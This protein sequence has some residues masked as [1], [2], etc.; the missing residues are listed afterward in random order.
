MLRILIVFAIV[1]ETC[2][3]RAGAQTAPETLPRPLKAGDAVKYALAHNPQ[4]LAL[5]A[6][7]AQ[8]E[9]LYA[10]AHANE[11]PAI[12]GTLQNVLER[13]QNALGSFYQYGL[14]PSSKF[15]ENTAQIGATWN[16]TTG[17]S[18]QVNA[19]EAKRL[20][21][22]ARADL[23][24]AEQQLAGKVA[25]DFYDLAARFDRVLTARAD[26]S[27]QDALLASAQALQSAGRIAAVDALRAQ[28]DVLRSQARLVS[29]QAEAD[30]AV[31]ALARTIGAP[32]STTFA[33]PE[34]IPEPSLPAIPLQTLIARARAQR[35][36]VVAAR[37]TL[38]GA[39]LKNTA[40]DTDLYPAVQVNGAFGNQYSPTEGPLVPGG[41]NPGFW[42]FGVSETF[43]LPLIEYGARRA[44]HAA[45][46][47]QIDSANAVLSAAE[48][49]VE[50]DVRSAFRNAL[51]AATNLQ[52]AK[53][54]VKLGLESARIA[55]LQYRTGLI[56]YT[57]AAGAEQSSL[58]ASQELT[59][60][61]V[62]YIS[63]VIRL[64]VALGDQDPL[65][66]A[67]VTPQ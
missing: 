24:R 33:V 65:A 16:I 67:M 49:S 8:D 20:V 14:T 29:A 63:S 52:T 6:V 58:T 50:F 53:Q 64:R 19:Q 9:S 21:E 46:R 54:A 15:S 7:V 23:Q 22:A 61:R 37:A 12:A 44:A 31:E 55:Q 35:F 34:Q 39:S 57:D 59:S 25:T 60:A 13:Q 41:G 30:N 56:S 51:T 11:Y 66:I 32:A 10:H 38:A 18:S 40:I 42:Q 36:D 4:I 45:A 5:R 28:V 17:G 62:F 47:A 48:D 3:L 43:S 27:Y 2:G 26:R 1:S